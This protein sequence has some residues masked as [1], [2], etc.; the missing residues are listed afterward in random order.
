MKVPKDVLKSS[1]IIEKEDLRKMSE[2][3]IQFI[4][5]L[6]F[7]SNNLCENV[8]DVSLEDKTS[9][10]DDEIFYLSGIFDEV[11]QPTLNF[12]IEPNSMIEDV[13]QNQVEEVEIIKM[14]LLIHIEKKKIVLEDDFIENVKFI[15]ERIE[16]QLGKG[17]SYLI[18]ICS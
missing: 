8:H 6:K 15:K 7:Q 12:C 2:E 3:N 18:I 5:D 16:Q 11:E 13:K 9:V 14:V 1:P 17:K 4:I 10:E